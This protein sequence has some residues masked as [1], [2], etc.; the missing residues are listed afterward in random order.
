MRRGAATTLTLLLLAPAAALLLAR[1][2]ALTDLE[3]VG[4]GAGCTGADTL[5]PVL[6]AGLPAVALV[7]VVPIALLSL[8]D[9]ARGW[10]WLALALVGT[11]LLDMALQA[12]IPACL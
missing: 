8:S 3:S 9:R 10:I 7:I 4:A 1:L 11:V 12:I 5:G 2:R 6:H